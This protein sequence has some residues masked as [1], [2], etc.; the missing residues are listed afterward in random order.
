MVH[1]CTC[2][3]TTKAERHQVHT[4]QKHQVCRHKYTSGKTLCHSFLAFSI[5]HLKKRCLL[6]THNVV[7]CRQLAHYASTTAQL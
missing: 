1:L 5:F 7:I 3:I 6:I 2:I 4:H